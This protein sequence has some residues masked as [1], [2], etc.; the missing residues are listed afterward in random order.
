MNHE[1]MEVGPDDEDVNF[2]KDNPQ[3]AVLCTVKEDTFLVGCLNEEQSCEWD[4]DRVPLAIGMATSK[5]HRFLQRNMD[6]FKTEFQLAQVPFDQFH[7]RGFSE[8]GERTRDTGRHTMESQALILIISLLPTRKQVKAEC[9]S[10]A[11]L[12]LK[13]IMALVHAPS[14]GMTS[15]LT[16]LS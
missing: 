15:S 1:A 13:N 16:A 4:W 2:N 10:A 9:K 5:D 14:L 6:E 8:N 7:Y 3:G 12:L 11:I